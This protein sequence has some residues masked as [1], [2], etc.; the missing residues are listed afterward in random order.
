VLKRGGFSTV[1]ESLQAFSSRTLREEV[2]RASVGCTGIAGSAIGQRDVTVRHRNQ[3]HFLPV[4][5]EVV[6]PCWAEVDRARGRPIVASRDRQLSADLLRLGEFIRR[7]RALLTTVQAA[8]GGGRGGASGYR[9][10]CSRTESRYPKRHTEV[11][12]AFHTGVTPHEV[13]I[14]GPHGGSHEARESDHSKDENT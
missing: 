13:R 11:A 1:K 6:R 12:A 10:G 5:A 9:V 2:R 14:L 4:R 7:I 8:P 3:D